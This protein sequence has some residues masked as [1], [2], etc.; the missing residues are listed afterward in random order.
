M[1]GFE[2]PPPGALKKEVF[3]G[4]RPYNF[5][6]SIKR[7]SIYFAIGMVLCTLGF[8]AYNQLH[9]HTALV[10]EKIVP[11]N[12]FNHIQQQNDLNEDQ[13]DVNTNHK[14]TRSQKNDQ[15]NKITPAAITTTHAYTGQPSDVPDHAS[16]KSQHDGTKLS[17]SHPSF[18]S[19]IN[20]IDN[21]ITSDVKPS[22]LIT[23]EKVSNNSDP[24]SADDTNFKDITSSETTDKTLINTNETSKNENLPVNT[25]NISSVPKVKRIQ[26]NSGIENSL[27][28]K[29]DHKAEKTFN[30]L[31]WS[32]GLTIGHS[33]Y[34][35]PLI[36]LPGIS[37]DNNYSYSASMDFPSLTAGIDVRAEKK[38]FFFELGLQYAH[39]SEK[40]T[41]DN[42]LYNPGIFQYYNFSG[43]TMNIDTGGGYF[44]YYWICDS[45]I[46][47]YDSV[48]TWKI[49]TSYIDHFDTINTK[50]YDTLYHPDWKNTY[51]FIELPMYAGWQ[52]NWGKVNLGIKTGPLISVLIGT[53]G[54]LPAY[55]TEQAGIQTTDDEFKRFRIGL[56]WQLS[57]VVSYFISERM[58]L[59]CQPYGRFN[60]TG[61]KAPSG[62][63]IKNNS[64]G[65][66]LGIR[67]FF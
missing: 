36:R 37:D 30:P 25:K 52:Y 9:E 67:Y 32:V 31:S 58:L 66:M 29:P 50:V 10:A 56:S 39:F 44:H 1:A 6:R 18:V 26:N 22:T 8:Y 21:T 55:A 63:A 14:E 43:Q 35:S 65:L 5:I 7:N 3:S 20:P 49:D 24:A 4:L 38:H 33:V 19:D 27:L 45:V 42:M 13:N 51:T 28:K 17:A 48:W 2:I 12:S 40:I 59:E 46:R 53:K 57:A 62:Y 61:I 41:S 60:L 16:G 34:Q 54:F 15:G 47:K 11:V 23:P 64:A